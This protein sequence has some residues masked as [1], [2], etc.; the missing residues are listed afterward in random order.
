[1]TGGELMK[2][3]RWLMKLD[4]GLKRITLPLTQHIDIPSFRPRIGILFLR[5]YY[6]KSTSYSKWENCTIFNPL[7]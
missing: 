4:R 3:I 2:F 1:M 5:G 7:I 6:V